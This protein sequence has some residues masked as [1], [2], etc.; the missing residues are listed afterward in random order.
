MSDLTREEFLAA[1]EQTQDWHRNC[2]KGE[3]PRCAEEPTIDL[4]PE[5]IAALLEMQE[6]FPR[7]IPVRGEGSMKKR[8]RQ[9]KGGYPGSR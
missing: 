7:A 8:K 3:C 9:T 5:E 6:R 4:Y 1:L 2:S